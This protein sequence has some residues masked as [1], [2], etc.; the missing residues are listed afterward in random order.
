VARCCDLQPQEQQI[1]ERIQSLKAD[2]EQQGQQLTIKIACDLIG[3]GPNRL[4]RLPR[5]REYLERHAPRMRTVS[6]ETF[7]AREHKLLLQVKATI[8]TLRDQAQQ[9]TILN[10]CSALKTSHHRLRSYPAVWELIRQEAV[11][12]EE[13]QTAQRSQRE[14]ALLTRVQQAVANLRAQATPLT[15]ERVA[16]AAGVAPK[17]VERYHRVHDWVREQCMQ[18]RSE[19][20]AIFE[21]QLLTQTQAVIATL[22]AE[23]VPITWR[24]LEARLHHN[25][26]TLQHYP[27]VRAAIEDAIANEPPV[28]QRRFT[29]EQLGAAVYQAIENLQREDVS[30]TIASVTKAVGISEKTIR[31]YPDVLAKI[32]TICEQDQ[33]ERRQ[34]KEQSLFDAIEHA[35]TILRSRGQRITVRELARSLERSRCNVH[36]VCRKYPRIR[37]LVDEAKSG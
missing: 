21:Q 12:S 5:V 18:A 7:Q 22:N 11:S 29:E 13:T 33:N 25:I 36:E 10:I 28:D 31:T 24:G 4:K 8:A 32:K 16:R 6:P 3:C 9:V 23:H 34:Q 1:L 20:Q 35:I 27:S 15:Q 30:L 26:Q 37:E 19:R 17:T 14:A 2:L